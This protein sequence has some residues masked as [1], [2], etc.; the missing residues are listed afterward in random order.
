MA[1]TRSGTITHRNPTWLEN[2]WK[3]W[4]EGILS[5]FHLIGWVILGVVTFIGLCFAPKW[6]S[7][8]AFPWPQDLWFWFGKETALFIGI[9]MLYSGVK[10]RSLWNFFWGILILAFLTLSLLLNW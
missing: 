9:N 2:R 6:T 3:Q 5:L 1:Y 10:G 4:E 7:T 8:V